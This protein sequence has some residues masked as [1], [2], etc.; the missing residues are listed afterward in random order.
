MATQKLSMAVSLP[1]L[2]FNIFAVIIN[3]NFIHILH[4][5]LS[6]ALGS[7]LQFKQHR[8]SIS[9]SPHSDLRHRRSIRHGPLF[10]CLETEVPR[11]RRER[12]D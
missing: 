6:F 10:G 8:C 9:K 7:Q 2:S 5:F 11:R 1:I 4:N 12:F 3:N